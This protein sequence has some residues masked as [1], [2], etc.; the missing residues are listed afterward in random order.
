MNLKKKKQL[1]S[2]C[3]DTARMP[4]RKWSSTVSDKW[5]SHVP[6]FSS[7]ANGE[8]KPFPALINFMA[9]TPS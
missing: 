9:Y 1:M 4:F 2:K 3:T 5:L 8:G 7:V 6:H